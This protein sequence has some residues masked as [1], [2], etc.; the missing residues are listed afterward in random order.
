[1][2]VANRQ[3]DT[4]KGI[5]DVW[6]SHMEDNPDPWGLYLRTALATLTLSACLEQSICLKV[7]TREVPELLL[8]AKAPVMTLSGVDFS[9]LCLRVRCLVQERQCFPCNVYSDTKGE[10]SKV[11]RASCVCMCAEVKSSRQG[12]EGGEWGQETGK[13]TEAGTEEARQGTLGS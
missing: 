7:V 11:K 2:L 9:I 8:G 12:E 10:Y 6:V 1:M 3:R 5:Q 4:H 13:N